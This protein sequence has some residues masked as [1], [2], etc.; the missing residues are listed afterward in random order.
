MIKRTYVRA[1][2]PPTGSII[3]IKLKWL[4]LK[5]ACLKYNAQSYSFCHS[6]SLYMIWSRFRQQHQYF[7]IANASPTQKEKKFSHGAKVDPKSRTAIKRKQKKCENRRSVKK[8][9]LT[10]KCLSRGK[11]LD[12]WLRTWTLYHFSFHSHSY[13]Y[14]VITHSPYAIVCGLLSALGERYPFSVVAELIKT[15]ETKKCPYELQFII[16]TNKTVE[17]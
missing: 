16:C 7:L 11:L 6:D 10:I 8:V 1:S 12:N 15:N 4:N 17:N 14:I 9:H 2:F 13:S 5:T 3:I